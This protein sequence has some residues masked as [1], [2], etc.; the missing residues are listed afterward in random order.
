[1]GNG[2]SRRMPWRMIK[3]FLLMSLPL[4][5]CGQ[6]STTTKNKK[7]S[8]S[9]EVLKE[10]LDTI[11]EGEME[12]THI[13]GVGIAIVKDGKTI[14]KK[15]YGVADIRTDRKVDPDSTIFRIGSISK[16]LTLLALTKLI[17]D[18][19]L[20][21]NEDVS[22]YIDG[23]KNPKGFSEA[24]E[25]QHLL[26]HTTGFDQIGIGRH[27]YDFELPLAERKAKRPHLADF[28]N[29]GNLR[30][31]SPAGAYYRY[32]T[33]GT[34]LAGAII[35]LVTG[36]RFPEAMKKEFFNPLGMYRSFVEVEEEHRNH[37][38]I[39]HG[40]H[41]GQ[42]QIAPYE[43]YLTTPASSID[44]TPADMGRLLEVLTGD[45]G[46]FFS[47]KMTKEILGPQF[48]PHPEFV[49]KTHG[50]E[51]SRLWGRAPDAFEIHTVGHGGDMLGYKA[52]MLVVPSLKLGVFVAANRNR[53]AGGGPVS[54]WRP[55]I[56]AL[57]NH[58]GVEKGVQ[59]FTVPEKD[60]GIDLRE[61]VGDYYYGVFCHSCTPQEFDQ[62]GWSPSFL[63]KFTL[64]NGL[65]TLGEDHYFPA[66]NDVFVRAD[67]YEKLFFGR[68]KR[69]KIAYFVFSD[70]PNVFERIEN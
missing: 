25:M 9:F 20:A 56:N 36:S 66:G 11:V 5:S 33:Y 23:I 44:A 41:E 55:L 68:D 40:Y 18:G 34:T 7:S 1:M 52:F 62:G 24:V 48:R 43:V 14:Y 37:L 21:M 65:L 47:S 69:G 70:D 12:R 13:P 60:T 49:G 45:G 4:F 38:A 57:L 28:L 15:G 22:R 26:T 51:E 17:D 39:G 54:V 30:R 2:R 32:D 46:D 16:A 8:A 3:V 6:N 59:A 29:A 53:E 19:K 63:R 61:Y 67:G 27:I 58:Y 50:L 31:V 42:Y 64:E 10:T 35:E